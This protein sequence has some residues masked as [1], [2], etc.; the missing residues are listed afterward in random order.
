MGPEVKLMEPLHLL[1][2][3]GKTL[4]PF[5]RGLRNS[6]VKGHLSE[7][8]KNYSNS[9]ARIPMKHF[10]GAALLRF[11]R[12]EVGETITSKHLRWWMTI[13]GM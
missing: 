13:P 3:D 12:K 2:P 6:P 8:Q 5:Q 9:S 11:G 1:G 7:E 10:R 4:S